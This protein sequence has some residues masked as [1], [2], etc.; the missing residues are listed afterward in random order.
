MAKVRPAHLQNVQGSERSPSRLRSLLWSFNELR[1]VVICENA[2]SEGEK[3]AVLG[4]FPPCYSRRYFH[5]SEKN[6]PHCFIILFL[7]ILWQIFVSSVFIKRKI[8]MGGE[9]K[10]CV[11]IKRKCFYNLLITNF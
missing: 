5:L 6:C 7:G 2:N 10:L 9:G 11:G 3:W 8:L 4:Y 1:S